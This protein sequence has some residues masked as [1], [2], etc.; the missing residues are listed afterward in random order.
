[1][2]LILS[3]TD[4][5]SDID[6]SAATPAVRG[7]D[8]NTGI[9]FGTDTVGISTGGTSALSISASQ[10]VTL[11]NALP[12]ASGGTG[13]TTST[14]TGAVV[15][16]TSP[17]ISSPT[18]NGTPVMGASIITSG[19]AVTASGTSVDFTSLPAWIKR[20]TI[21]IQGVTTNGSSPPTMR[22]GTSGGF[23]TSGYA[24]GGIY[25]GV[26][27]GSGNRTDS[28]LISGNA[29]DASATLHGHAVLTNIS[30]N[31]WVQSFVLGQSNSAYAVMGGGSISLAGALTQIRITTANGTDAFDAGTINILFE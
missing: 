12:V 2:T 24:S 26:T 28:L 9:F 25:T 1:M 21:M 13:V 6:G 17:T 3:G 14:G 22:L 8:A 11:A 16:G 23:V 18:I 29:F 19:T 27:T 15:L 7:T 30:G 20:I 10:A 4:G 5:L 31:A